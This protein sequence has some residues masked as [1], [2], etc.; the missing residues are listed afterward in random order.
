MPCCAECRHAHDER[1][2][3]EELEEPSLRCGAP[4]PFWVPVQVHDYQSWVK[5]SDGQECRAFESK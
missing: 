2:P 3:G 1:E 4:V 5:W